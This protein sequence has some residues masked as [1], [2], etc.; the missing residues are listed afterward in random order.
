MAQDIDVCFLAL[1]SIHKLRR[2]SVD[3]C[4]KTKTIEKAKTAK[5]L[6]FLVVSKILTS[7]KLE[8][9]C[10]ISFLTSLLYQ[11]FLQKT[12]EPILIY[13]IKANPRMSILIYSKI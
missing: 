4:S 11:T 12:N 10:F 6:E 5:A 1:N 3:F 9:S 7:R 2:K 13:K 8:N